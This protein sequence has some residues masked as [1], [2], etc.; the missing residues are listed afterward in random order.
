MGFSTALSGL[1]AAAKDLQVTGNNI[2]NANTTGFKE[3]RTEFADV[4]SSSVSGVAKTAAGAG[5]SVANV[6]QQ[7]S[8]GNLN[9]TDNNLDLAITG[10]GFFSLATDVAA[11]GPTLYTRSG[12]FK[13]DN[14]GYVVNNQGNNLM[15]FKPNGT[16]VAEGFSEGVFLPLRVNSS[17]GAPEATSKVLTTVNLD[18]EQIKPIDST[19]AAVPLDPTNPKSY[20]HTS[21]VTIYDSQGNSHIASTYFI[22]DKV[23]DNP[24]S[25]TPNQWQSFFFID[26]IAFNPDGTVST[27]G[28]QVSTQLE[29]DSAGILTNPTTAQPFGPFTSTD[30]DPGLNVEPLSF[31][32]DFGKSTQFSTNFS[33]QDLS[34]DGLPAGNLTGVSID[35]V[36]VI[37]ANFSNGGSDILGKVALT[38]F[39]NPQGL[40]KIGDTSWKESVAS[41]LAV[42]G[43]SG[44]GS[45]GKIQSGALESST[46]DL[47]AQLVHLIV[48]QQAY[49]ANAQTITTEKTIM[50]TILNA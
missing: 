36:G 22:A 9:F 37:S 50:Q 13:L 42:P 2:A 39:A 5:V 11:P 35:D 31:T 15:G 1:T 27:A 10:E 33:V 47:A 23:G 41:G 3:S 49:Q 26:G 21:S 44:S 4:Y 38:R 14:A 8:Q 16:T 19:G 34:Q 20:N 40:T 17:Q 43:Q 18:A 32:F 6:A 46:V 7:F 28:A 29:F 12:E 30:I 48:A 45:F 25:G 24:E